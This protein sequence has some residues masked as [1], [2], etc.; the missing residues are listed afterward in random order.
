MEGD[1]H[2]RGR[3]FH[4]RQAFEGGIHG[5]FRGQLTGVIP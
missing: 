4:V 5:V 1:L 3:E 2:D